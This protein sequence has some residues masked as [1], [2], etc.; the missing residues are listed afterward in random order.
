ELSRI[1]RIRPQDEVMPAGHPPASTA[2][3]PP[4]ADH[5]RTE[6]AARQPPPRRPRPRP[7]GRPRPRPRPRPRAGTARPHPARARAPPAAPP[8]DA[9]LV[10]RARADA[11]RRAIA[12]RFTAVA[13]PVWRRDGS[14]RAAAEETL[15]LLRGTR[16]PIDRPAFLSPDGRRSS[17]PDFVW[18]D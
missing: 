1:F 7:R 2:G 10:L 13:G 11:H 3:A 4:P 15:R 8:D 14:F 16:R 9:L 5:A 18:W 12:S 6:K 17:A